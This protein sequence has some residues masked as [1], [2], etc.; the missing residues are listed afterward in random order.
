[1]G[2]I[3]R[4]SSRT[5]RKFCFG[6]ADDDDWASAVEAHIANLRVQPAPTVPSNTVPQQPQIIPA[7]GDASNS[8]NNNNA[9]QQSSATDMAA[10]KTEQKERS[11]ALAE[12]SLMA[13]ILASKLR[14]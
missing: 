13:K 11:E 2:L 8:N 12:E 3:S 7:N 10:I 5:Y 1:M 6:M 14:E 9:I 4:V